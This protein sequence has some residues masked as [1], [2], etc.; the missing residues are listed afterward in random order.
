MARVASNGIIEINRGDTATF[1]VYV[2]V[3]T[4]LK[5]ILYEL[6][7]GDNIYF[8]LLEPHQKWEN[9]ILKKVYDYTSFDSKHFCIPIHFYT[10]DTEY[11]H[12][13]T[14]YYEIKLRKDAKNNDDGFESVETI[15]PRT[16]FFIVE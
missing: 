1:P 8:A 16:K 9:A 7:E 2:N 13:G 10:E 4:A 12:P 3:G 6:R 11:L 15:V 5:T 14:Y